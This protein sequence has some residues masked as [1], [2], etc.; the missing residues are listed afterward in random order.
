MPCRGVITLIPFWAT[1][2]DP[3]SQL[4]RGLVWVF[5]VFWFVVVV[6]LFFNQHYID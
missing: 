1:I 5:L 6:F 3:V 2:F 4:G